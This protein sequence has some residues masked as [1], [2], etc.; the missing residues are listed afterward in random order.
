[1]SR[2]DIVSN[3]IEYLRDIE[4]EFENDYRVPSLWL[5]PCNTNGVIEVNPA[6]YLCENL[7]WIATQTRRPIMKI[8]RNK[9][10]DWIHGARIYSC[11]VRL[12]SAFDH[13]GDGLLGGSLDD[14]TCNRSGIR[15]TGTFLKLTGMLPYLASLKINT[16]HLLPITEIGKEGRKGALGSPYAIR[17]PYRL[18]P[19]LA[20]PLL[21][22]P[23]EEQF[24][25][26]IQAAHH[27]GISVIMEFV[28]RT[29]SRDSRWIQ[30]APDWF[31]WIDEQLRDRSTAHDEPGTFG[32]PVFEPDALGKIKAA[33]TSGSRVDLLPPPK[34][35]RDLFYQ[36]PT[37]EAVFIDP[38]GRVRARTAN[39]I[40]KVP[41]AFADWPPDDIQPPWGDVTY[42]RIYRDPEDH[43]NYMAYNTLRMYDAQLATPEHENTSLWNYIRGVIPYYQQ[44]YGIDG[45][46]LDM[47]HALPTKLTKLIIEDAKKRD[48]HFIFIDENFSETERSSDKGFNL[49]LGNI[50]IFEQNH[51]QI[52]EL[53]DIF[54][55]QNLEL[56]Y[57]ATAETHNS[58]RITLRTP[59][60]SWIRSL[61]MLNAL[62][63]NSVLFINAGFELG[64]SLPVNTGLLFKPEELKIFPAEI[65]PLFSPASLNW[66]NADNLVE[67]VRYA[68]SLRKKFCDELFS[69]KTFKA[70]PTGIPGQ[71]SIE[72][73]LTDGQ[74]SAW[75]N[76]ALDSNMDLTLAARA[77]TLCPV[78]ETPKPLPAKLEP[79]TCAVVLLR[80]P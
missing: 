13:N 36:P 42:L 48:P 72:R 35:Y 71:Y 74:L 39:A 43:F 47:G 18:E 2:I 20:D 6:N 24:N 53:L 63:P 45:V 5:L 69:P 66:L 15:E 78:H 4:P 44:H 10:G 80:Y 38:S 14:I 41:G 51:Y 8:D 32:N 64:E 61:L 49:K 19:S 27:L 28:L 9:P 7:E 31:Y 3:C 30:Q 62:L 25:L 17:D 16:I 21:A 70:Q 46:F 68:L 75:F 67:D 59:A 50:W 1:M 11:M 77:E 79:G 73:S 65:L 37:K 76:F 23:V 56:P 58:P 22:W 57:L 55:H 54:Q 26:F 29:A 33:I 34:A 52:G 60:R 12:A 40:L